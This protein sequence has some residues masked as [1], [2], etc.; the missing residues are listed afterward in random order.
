[1]LSTNFIY[2]RL[3]L[4]FIFLHF[5]YSCETNELEIDSDCLIQNTVLKNLLANS[6]PF[7]L[8]SYQLTSK[9]N[10]VNHKLL[11]IISLNKCEKTDITESNR[12]RSYESKSSQTLYL[13]PYILQNTYFFDFYMTINNVYFSLVQLSSNS[14]NAKSH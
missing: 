11:L 3:V 5:S 13:E 10:D 7:G 6:I 8:N 9:T 2:F 14:V 4:F 1:M 12:C